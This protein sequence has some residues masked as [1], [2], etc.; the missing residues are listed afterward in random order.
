MERTNAATHPSVEPD[1][2][3][4]PLIRRSPQTL[5]LVI[6]HLR[7]TISITETLKPGGPM[8]KNGLRWRNR[9]RVILLFGSMISLLPMHLG[10]TE[11]IHSAYFSPAPGA[12]AIIWVAKE[13]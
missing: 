6:Q 13:A 9:V 1:R 4:R 8:K 11:R 7:G 5:T 12:S 3:F 10:A 2:L